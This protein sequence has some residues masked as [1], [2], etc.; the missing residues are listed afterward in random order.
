[1]FALPRGASAADAAAPDA[2]HRDRRRPRRPCDWHRSH[3]RRRLHRVLLP[4]AESTFA[5]QPSAS[6][7]ASA[8]LLRRAVTVR[9]S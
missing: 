1:M 5:V 8:P 2:S 3:V 4:K 6:P 9:A 7:D